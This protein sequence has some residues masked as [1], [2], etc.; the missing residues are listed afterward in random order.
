MRFHHL[1][2][3]VVSLEQAVDYLKTILPVREQS[4]IVFDEIQK[5]RLQ[6]VDIGNCLIEL[7]EGVGT[8][9][10]VQNLLKK[11]MTWYHVCYVTDRFDDTIRQLT[12]SGGVVLQKEKAALFEK[13]QVV[14]M[15][16]K[17]MGLIELLEA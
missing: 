1:G 5:V 10:P 12:A 7:V 15:Y 14:F 11:Q 13:K 3:A 16:L 6:L 9:N 2:L 8:G 17:H 4:A